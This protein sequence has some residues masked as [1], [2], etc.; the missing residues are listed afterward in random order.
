[1]TEERAKRKLSAI[2]SADVKGYSRLMGEDELETVRT[3]EAYRV[4]ITEVTENYRG[5]VVDSPG[6]NV[7]AEFASIVDAVESAVEIQRQLK[8]RNAELNENRRMEFRIGINLG[9][10]IEE[11]FRIYGDGVNI[12][13][14]VEGLAE[15]G[16]I[17]ISGTAYDQVKNKLDLDYEYL[18]EHSVKNIVEPVR[19]YRFTMEPKPVE[20]A[21]SEERPRPTTW[22]W[23]TVGGLLAIIVV[24]GTFLIWNFYFRSAS[25]QKKSASVAITAIP[26]SGRASI[27]VLP[28]KN[29]SKDPEQEYFSEGITNDII[30]DLSK[31]R[32]LLV[33][34][35]NTVFTYKGKSVNVKKVSQDLGVRYV[36][37]GSIH[38]LG[39]KLRI[40]AQLIDG[41]TGHHLWAERFDRHSEALF[42]VQDEIVQTIV[43]ILSIKVDEAERARAMRKDTDNLEAYD[44]ALRGKE[45][46]LSGG[47]S[48]TIKAK[49]MFR[50]AI[51][52]DSRYASAYVG[53]GW[54]YYVEAV[55]G[56]TEFPLKAMEK[57]LSLG[58]QAMDIVEADADVHAL[59]GSVNLRLENYDLAINQ[60]NRAIELNPNHALSHLR[61]GTIMLYVGR[62]DESIQLLEAGIRYNPYTVP[63]DYGR[64]AL[65]YYIKGNYDDAIKILQKDLVRSPKNPFHH[66]ILAAAYAQESMMEEATRSAEAV[67]NLFPFFE[68]DSAF[69]LFRNQE[70]RNKIIEGLRKAGFK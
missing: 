7:L 16:G 25:S 24:A 56:G 8:A 69:T 48:E 10:V 9:D 33:I 21:T 20:T 50:R 26:L 68:V 29:L 62:A 60:L 38:K 34:A 51:E 61:L 57:A 64:L 35:S 17:C 11:G 23:A 65:A 22:R 2:L 63:D 14:R 54:A 43:T 30:T 15:G 44:Y 46:L 5:R 12:A 41:A 31:F 52:L 28:F 40:N 55:A 13:A 32:E 58:Q 47:R 36:L 45:L 27:A 37:E 49:E 6:D 67:M 3:L 39:N 4:V 19:V 66:I 53:L 18:G 59:L 1:V 70:D 42:E